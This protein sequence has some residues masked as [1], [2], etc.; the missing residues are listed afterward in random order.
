MNGTT[1][2][3]CEEIRTDDFDI[4]FGDNVLYCR[5]VDTAFMWNIS[6]KKIIDL[7]DLCAKACG[8]YMTIS[9]Y[10]LPNRIFPF[11]IHPQ[12]YEEMP[13]IVGS[14]IIDTRGE[15]REYIISPDS[16]EIVVNNKLL[17]RRILTYQFNIGNKFHSPIKS[18]NTNY[19][20]SIF[21]R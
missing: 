5:S 11:I 9:E 10:V 7:P 19:R 17:S 12:S 15:D 4:Q 8:D 13:K 14:N 6:Q 16:N 21:L 3:L 2:V 20:D 18:K 1:L